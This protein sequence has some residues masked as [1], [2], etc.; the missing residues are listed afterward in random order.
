M[1]NYQTDYQAFII[2]KV[3][4]LKLFSYMGGKEKGLDLLIGALLLVNCSY[5][6]TAVGS[7]DNCM[8]LT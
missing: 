5:S 6:L 4:Y 3:R 1:S 8:L 2:I 7:G